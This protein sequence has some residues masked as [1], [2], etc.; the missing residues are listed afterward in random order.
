MKLYPAI[1][2]LDGGAVR[3]VKGDFQEKKVYD[4]DPLRAAERWVGEGA[5]QLH[6]VDLD[7]ARDG[8]PRNL[9][10]L[11]R[12]AE[13]NAPVQFGGGLRSLA[14][15]DAAIE[16]GAA[17]V[18]LGTAIFTQPMLP[19][20]AIEKHGPDRVLVS[21][22]ARDGYVATHGWL[23]A[24]TV[25]VREAIERWHEQG[26]AVNGFVYTNIDHDGMLNG[27]DGEEAAMVA[28]AAGDGSVILSGG[29]GE[30]E[31]LR[32]L[33]HLREERELESLTGVIVGKALYEHRFTVAEAQAALGDQ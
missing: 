26:R 12:I 29:I 14:A 11:E 31:H 18:I 8:S 4:E 25:P 17:R 30:L 21:I 2:I 5:R 9:D 1:D 3:L 13:L 33:A 7:G 6:V 24:T 19:F 22:D 23:E 28:E 16:A 27:I 20:E 10:H 32:A 15:V